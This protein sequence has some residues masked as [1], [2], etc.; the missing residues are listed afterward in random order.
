MR[1]LRVV[2]AVIAV[3]GALTAASGLI[4][5]AA[6]AGAAAIHFRVFARTGLRLTDIVWTGRQFLYVDNTTNRVAAAGPSGTPLAPFARMPRQVEE[7]RC[8]PSPGAHGFAAGDIYCH[9]PDNKIYRLSADGKTVAVFATLPHAPRSDGALA[10]DTV[11][12]FGFALIVATG[13]SGSS[14]SRG[15]AVFAIDPSGRVRRIG[16]YDNPGGADEIAIAPARFGSA[17]GQALLSVDAGSSGSVV[18]MDAHG[19][20]RTLLSLPDGPNP[21]V[22]LTRGQ[23]PPAGAAKPGLY[24]TD[25]LSHNVYFAPGSELAPFVGDVVVGSELRGLFWVVRPH[26]SGV[27]ATRLPT[28]LSGKA[29]NL[30]GAAYVAS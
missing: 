22:V 10:F 27:V 20:A 16:R 17:S 11:G 29:Y 23:T 28:T 19:H 5:V 18:A 26:G 6:G 21:I 13:Q 8:R 14:T 3:S 12:A 15:G 24:V 2:I 4:S 30:E 9:A 25:T 7:T 1:S